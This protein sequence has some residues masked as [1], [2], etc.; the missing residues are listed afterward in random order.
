VARDAALRAEQLERDGSLARTHRVVVADREDGEVG[1]VQAAD[2]GHVA[3]DA[4]VAGEVDALS[5]GAH[6]DAA[7]LAHVRAVV[8]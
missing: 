4:R 8:R 7:G 2:E 1:L 3:E 6:D 5:L